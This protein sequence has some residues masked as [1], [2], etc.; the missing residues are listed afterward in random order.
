MYETMDE[1]DSVA[2]RVGLLTFSGFFSGAAYAAFKGLP[3]RTTAL[4]VAG[5]CAMVG[6][7]LFG[8]ERL[9][10][11][12]LR[13]RIKGNEQRLTLS[14]YA[15]GGVV[16]GGINGFLYQKQPIR[17]MM[18]SVPLMLGMGMIELGMKRKKQQRIEEI[19]QEN[20]KC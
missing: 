11:I 14:S 7:S 19:Q 4:K 2:N 6:T 17:G 13:E 5:S 8:A 16:G 12:Y 15:F 3:R 20:I 18:I 1:V 9:A 10:N